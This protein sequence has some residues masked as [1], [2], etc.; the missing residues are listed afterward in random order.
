MI[1]AFVFVAVFVGA[2]PAEAQSPRPRLFNLLPGAAWTDYSVDAVRGRSQISF[3]CQDLTPGES[4]GGASDGSVLTVHLKVILS[5][6]KGGSGWFH[7]RNRQNEPKYCDLR[8]GYDVVTWE[9]PG[10]VDWNHFPNAIIVGRAYP[11]QNPGFRIANGASG[12]GSRVWRNFP[13]GATAPVG[14]ATDAELAADPG[15]LER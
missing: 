2:V 6:V 4:W 7:S 14:G 5:G 9:M 1:L 12:L 3:A 11:D 10:P 15:E 8:K 13:T